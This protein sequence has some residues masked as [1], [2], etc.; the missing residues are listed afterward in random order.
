MTAESIASKLW[1]QCNVLR[2]D[3]VTY[4]QYLNELTY[5]LF[6]KLSEIKGFETEI[7][8]E[9]RWKMFVN[10][11]DNSKA[12]ALYRD[13]LANVIPRLPAIASRKSIGMLRPVCVS[14]S[15]SIPSFKP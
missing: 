14:R 7:P 12:F 4:H 5:I 8:E 15:T 6:L 13:F 1:N 9:Y 10:E 11:K 2:D 3:G